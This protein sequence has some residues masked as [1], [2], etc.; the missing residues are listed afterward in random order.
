MVALSNSTYDG[1]VLFAKNSDR[2]PNEASML[3]IIPACDY[4]AGSRVKCTYIEI[5]Q[6]DHTYQVLLAKPFWMW[7]TEMGA[8]EF[9]VV[10]G[11][12]AVFS[13]EPYGK[14]PGLLGMD[15]IR[16]ALER[17]S[18]ANQA[19]ELITLLLG[20]YGQSGNC[21][22]THKMYYHNSF[23]IAD[24]N[25]AWV[26][27]T[28]GKEWA[29]ERVHD[30]RSISNG[31]TIQDKWDLSSDHLV[32]H[33]IQKGWCRNQTEFNMAKCYSDFLYTRFSDSK[34]RQQCSTN[35]L[36]ND[37]G[38]LSVKSLMQALRFHG[39]DHFDPS[40]G[41]LGADVCMHAGFGPARGSQ[42]AGSMITQIKDDRV[43]HWLTG[44]SAPCT[45]IFKPVW[46]DSGL[47]E[48]GAA[49]T[50]EFNPDSLFWKHEILH[51]S[52]I[53]NYPERISTVQGDRDNL[54]GRFLERAA[55]IENADIHAR[56]EFTRQC[57]SEA[58]SATNEW[59]NQVQKYNDKNL[60]WHYRSAWREF[61]KFAKFH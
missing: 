35:L 55:S 5:P 31:Y 14:E 24:K 49:P 28:A 19:L 12:E 15:I 22:F 13:K 43:T 21:G 51:R 39:N 30:I 52:I 8:N 17:S 41:I 1:S 40:H 34:K 29:A 46:M 18:S 26:L 10:I 45:G 57:F 9:G 58:D 37:K 32:E 50:G 42:S 33:A 25:E 48:M 20:K 60:P 47:P 6:V 53:Q 44:T 27:E 23:L 11:N 59:I 56:R 2:E 3:V 61:N 7:G 54:E 38:K 36:R 16:L 4:A